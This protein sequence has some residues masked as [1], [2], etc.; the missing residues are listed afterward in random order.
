MDS[1]AGVILCPDMNWQGFEMRFVGM[2][3]G[4]LMLCTGAVQA[5]T[6]LPD[7]PSEPDL[8]RPPA[9]SLNFY[10]LPGLVDMPSAEMLPEGQFTNGVSYFAGQGRYTLAFQPTDWM[11]ASFRYSM[12]PELANGRTLYDRSFDVRFRLFRETRRWPGITVGLQDFAGTGIYSGEFIAATKN[13]DTPA[14]GTSRLPGRLKVTA[15]LGWGRFGSHG[16]LGSTG[17]RPSRPAGDLGGNPG[18]NQWFRGPFAA[19]GGIEWQANDKLGFKV[20]YSSDAYVRENQDPSYPPV[21]NRRSS[22]NFGVEYQATPRTRLGAYYLYGSELGLNLQVQLSPYVPQAPPQLPAPYPIQPRPDPQL[23][24]QAWSTDWVEVAN[25]APLLRDKMASVLEVEGLLLESLDV[26]AETAELRFRNLRYRSHTVAIGRAARMMSLVLPDSIEVFRLVPMS[27]GLALSSVT[28]HRSDLENLEFDPYAADT[29]LVETRFS[30]AGPLS[31]TAVQATDVYP[32][33]SWSLAPYF[34]PGF[35]D[36]AQPFRLDVGAALA[37]T[38]KPA[39][40]W[41][42]AGAI[43]Q[44]IAGNL[45]GG[46]VSGTNLPPV[47]TDQALYAQ[48][49]T[50]IN[51]LYAARYWQPARQLYARI[52]AG[53]FEYG[54]GGL[55]TEL[56]WKPVNSRLALG[57]EANY[58]IKRDYDQLFGFQDYRIA[59]GHASAYYDFNNG[60]HAQVDVGRYLAGDWGATLGIDRV[61]NNG[62]SVG[63]FFTKTNVSAQEFGEGSFDKGIR[64]RIPLTWFLGTESQKSFG[65]TIRPIQRDGGARLNVPGRLYGQV[66]NAHRKALSDQW[67]RFWE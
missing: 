19:F 12:I 50:T 17:T 6:V 4:L 32:E 23:D 57:I 33:F 16:S 58:A 42:I 67:P 18:Y 20:E 5:Q 37:G 40:G 63:G 59:T 31:D 39:P 55:S 43:R 38:Y 48:Y 11:L 47:R 64:F 9:P 24:P 8:Q 3:C 66:R 56:L 29:M 60:F 44:R 7:V 49:D 21:F 15:G 45:A 26:T 53:Y 62:W 35:F 46:T 36:P 34:T 28:I 27:R 14:W 41:V 25:A 1:G 22:V 30:D 52:S 2:L 54:Y 51:T 13:F 10:G 61:F 65:T